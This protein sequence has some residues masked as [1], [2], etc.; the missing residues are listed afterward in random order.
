MTVHTHAFDLIGGKK[1]CLVTLRLIDLLLSSTG[2]LM[3]DVLQTV[4]DVECEMSYI[5]LKVTDTAHRAVYSA[6]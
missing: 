2:L 6:E 5:L 4:A 1:G 3:F